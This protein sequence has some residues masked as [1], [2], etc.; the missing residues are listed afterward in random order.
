[1]LVNQIMQDFFETN[2]INLATYE[3]HIAMVAFPMPHVTWYM[4]NTVKLLSYLK[5]HMHN[6][7]WREIDQMLSYA[8]DTL[9]WNLN[10]WQDFDLADKH[11]LTQ[12][13]FVS[14]SRLKRH[15]TYHGNHRIASKQ[16]MYEEIEQA[17]IRIE[18]TIDVILR[19]GA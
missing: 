2:Q 3:Y 4:R 13:D 10:S 18:S 1:M 17:I 14:V 11:H 16:M 6:M 8:Y 9:F 19:I 5:E 15:L 7:T 12:R